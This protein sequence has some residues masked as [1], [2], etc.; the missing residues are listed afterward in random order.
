MEESPPKL[1]LSALTG[2]KKGS[3]IAV[4]PEGAS[5]GRSNDNTVSI[6]DRELSRRHSLVSYHDGQFFVSD[7]GSTNGTY[8]QLAGPYAGAYPLNINDHI[9]VGRT[10]F[11]V[12]RSV[13]QA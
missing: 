3:L 4:T 5:M 6:P 7:L 11:S 10:G 12:N 2:P 9:L 13:K 8:V 1:T